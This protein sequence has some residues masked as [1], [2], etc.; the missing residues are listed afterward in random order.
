MA[1]LESDKNMKL[2]LPIYKVSDG[3]SPLDTNQLVFC[4]NF[5]AL[6][7]ECDTPFGKTLRSSLA[8]DFFFFSPKISMLRW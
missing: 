4:S 8:E 6:L 5:I 2:S 1:I 7:V 3:V